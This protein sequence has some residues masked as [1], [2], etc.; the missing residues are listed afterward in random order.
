MNI[1]QITEYMYHHLDQS[2][3]ME[4]VAKQF[5]YAPSYFSRK[6]KG[7]YDEPCASSDRKPFRS[8]IY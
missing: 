8:R 5:H 1:E 3:T 2:L 4:S 6:F 7:C